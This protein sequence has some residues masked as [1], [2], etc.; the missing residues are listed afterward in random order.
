MKKVILI[1][2]ITLIF[3]VGCT[4]TITEVNEKQVE[5]VQKE[6]YSENYQEP[7]EEP[8]EKDGHPKD[9]PSLQEQTKS[10]PLTP[11]EQ[12]IDNL[13]DEEKKVSQGKFDNL[14]ES[15]TSITHITD[16]DRARIKQKIELLEKLVD[17]H[18]MNGIE[19]VTTEDFKIFLPV[20]KEEVIFDFMG[21][22][23][24]G[25]KGG[26]H[27]EGHPGIDIE[28]KDGTPV[29]AM[30]D[31]SISKPADSGHY[32]YETLNIFHENNFETYYTGNM[33]DFVFAEGG[34]VKAGEIIAYYDGDNSIHYGLQQKVPDLSVCPV[35][36]MD[37]TAK[38]DLEELFEKARYA[39]RNKFPLLC[40]PCPE[41]GCK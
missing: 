21:I 19:P 26:D 32:D 5:E 38:K 36:Y 4:E 30:A 18:Q 28:A 11:L 41:T 15:L 17:E 10:L 40:N 9:T 37:E 14:K 13:L 31:G 16:E 29:R 23:P 12:E 22:W 27:P 7:V 35:D 33:K 1:L 34:K 25:V 6:E 2:L 8:V 24:F 39:E 3:L 20:K